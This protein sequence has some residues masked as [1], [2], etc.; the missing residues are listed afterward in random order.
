MNLHD[1]RPEAGL[2]AGTEG[3]ITGNA[4]VYNQQPYYRNAK[5][6]IRSF[7]RSGAWQETNCGSTSGQQGIGRDWMRNVCENPP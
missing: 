7:A 6:K 2:P 1:V 4:S 3:T 5:L